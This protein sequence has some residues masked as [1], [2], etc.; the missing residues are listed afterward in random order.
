[1]QIMPIV[2]AAL[3]AVAVTTLIVALRN[4]KRSIRADDRSYVDPLSVATG[5]CYFAASSSSV[6][7]MQ[8]PVVRDNLP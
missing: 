5:D 7:R 4:I 1:M 2:I 3:I 6:T 8:S